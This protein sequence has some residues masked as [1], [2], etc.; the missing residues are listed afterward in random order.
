[1][2]V[3]RY[4]EAPIVRKEKEKSSSFKERAYCDYE[5]YLAYTREGAASDQNIPT[6]ILA[7]ILTEIGFTTGQALAD[8]VGISPEK[9]N[10]IMRIKYKT[11]KFTIADKI[12]CGIGAPQLWWLHPSLKEY[13]EISP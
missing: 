11:T 4:C 6:E 8:R 1:M 5:H 13:Y 9:A 3:C 10:E 2:R 7:S 12:L